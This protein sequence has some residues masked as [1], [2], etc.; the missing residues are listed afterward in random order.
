MQP[1]ASVAASETVGGALRLMRR[2]GLG[3]LPIE[4]VQ[5]RLVSYSDQL[6]LLLALRRAP[7]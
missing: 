2:R 6:Q 3:G 5:S 1:P 4:D 7:P